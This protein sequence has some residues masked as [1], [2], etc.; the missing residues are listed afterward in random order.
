MLQRLK[1]E[2]KTR[3]LQRW[4]TSPLEERHL[5][6][7]LRAR[8][9][10][11]SLIISADD[12]IS[13][14]SKRLLDLAARAIGTAADINLSD[15]SDRMDL[16]SVRYPDFWPGEHY[17][18]LAS[19]VKIERPTLIVE[20]G[21]AQG[22][23]ALALKKY[24]PAEG[25]VAT[26]DIVPWNEITDTYLRKADFEDGRLAHHVG[27]LSEPTVFLRHTTLLE[28]ADVVFVDAPKDGRFEPIF[29]QNLERLR[30]RKPMLLILDDIRVWNMLATWRQLARPK[31]DM[32]SFGHWSGTG[33]VDWTAA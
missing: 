29:L 25:S 6:V 2:V 4:L 12:E 27:D 31:L 11:Y 23:S 15:I 10:E 8:H 21:T 32:T 28:Q 18:L 13:R 3:L 26:F 24:L 16:G 20:I 30:F 5:T 33:F 17:R 19:I 7:P 14:P 1:A 22:L 9:V